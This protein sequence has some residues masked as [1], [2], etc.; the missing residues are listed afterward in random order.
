MRIDCCRPVVRVV[1]ALVLRVA[2]I[3]GPASAQRSGS[4][5]I[6]SSVGAAACTNCIRGPLPVHT[7][8]A[9]G[10]IQDSTR[11][12]AIE[13]SDAYYTRLTIHRIGSYAELPLFATEYIL[14]QKLLTEENDGTLPKR[15][16]LASG[17]SLVAGGLGVLFTV[18]TV[19]GVWNLIE[20]RHN[21]DGQARR[22]IHSLAMLAADGGFFWT[23]SVAGQA[24]RSDAGAAQ[25]RNI[26]IASMSL[27]TASTLMMWLWKK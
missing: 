25:H 11:H 14:G 19:T 13:Y 27:A 16:S 18:N 21:P 4:T 12:R 17:H 15:S 5:A 1:A 3:S 24:K 10:A 2:L 26:A 7:M 9:D 6:D 8:P 20:A 23:A 22:W